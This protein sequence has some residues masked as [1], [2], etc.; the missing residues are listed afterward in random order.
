VPGTP[1]DTDGR[2]RERLRL[3]G[4]AIAS[5]VVAASVALLVA[6]A[7]VGGGDEPTPV[8]E[9]DLTPIPTG[10]V[11]EDPSGDPVPA[12]RFTYFDGRE[13]DL[14]DFAG[15]PLVVNFFASWCGPCESELPAFAAVHRELGDE[16][17][18]LGMD[19]ID[20][21]ASGRATAERAGVTYDLASDPRSGELFQA[22]GGSVMPYT[23]FV[24]ADQEVVEVHRGEL[25]QDELEDIIRDRLLG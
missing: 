18:F 15:R 2:R 17:A 4:L 7:L 14:T 6:G 13:G 11:G 16:V 22:F 9:I 21:V 19:V 8:G 20:T 12:A 10:L 25:S 23:V 5:T 24:S 3:I 1:A